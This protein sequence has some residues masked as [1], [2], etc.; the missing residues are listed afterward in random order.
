MQARPRL[1]GKNGAEKIA[2]TGLSTQADEKEP[3]KP[4]PQPPPCVEKFAIFGLTIHNRTVIFN[5]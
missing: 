2:K 5:S 1:Q 3:T 4:S